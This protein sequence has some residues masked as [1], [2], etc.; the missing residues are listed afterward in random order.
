MQVSYITVCSFRFRKRDIE[1]LVS[2]TESFTWEEL[3]TR[4]LDTGKLNKSAYITAIQTI[5]KFIT[6]LII[7]LH[8]TQSTVRIVSNHEMIYT[9]WYPFDASASPA[10]EIINMLQVILQP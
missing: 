6:V 4:N 7:G 2:L 1:R 10:Y 3:P 9:A 8:G 5:A